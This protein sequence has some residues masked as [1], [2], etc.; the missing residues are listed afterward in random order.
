[1]TTNMTGMLNAQGC[2]VDTVHTN[3]LAHQNFQLDIPKM[4]IQNVLHKRPKLYIYKIQ[5][6]NEVKVQIKNNFFFYDD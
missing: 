2:C 3:L 1:M 6:L 5:S 4:M